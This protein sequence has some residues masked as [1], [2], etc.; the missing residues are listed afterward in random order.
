MKQLRPDLHIT[1]IGQTGDQLG[2]I[3]EQSEDIDRV[4]NVRAGK[5]RRYHGEGWRQLLDFSTLFKNLRDAF[6][7]LVGTWQSF[8]LLGKLR[9]AVIFTRGSYVSVPVCWAA[10]LRGIPYITHDSDAIPG[11]ANRII[12]PWAKIHAVALPKE[13]YSAYPADKIMTVGVPVSRN[14]G[15]VTSAQA[16][17]WREQLGL[18]QDSK[19]LLVTGGGNGADRLNKAVIACAPELLQRYP[20]LI[21]VHLTG[22]HLEA[23]ARRRYKQVLNPEEFERVVIKGFVTNLYQY[24]GAADVVVARA[25][26]TS[27]AEFAVQ[28]KACVIV[29]NPQLTGGHQPKNAKVL[30][31]RKAIR[32]V[33]EANLRNDPR[34]LM[35]A[36]TDLF[37]HPGKAK[38]LG[39]KLSALAQPNAAHL[40][41]EL[42]LELAEGKPVSVSKTHAN[43]NQAKSNHVLQKE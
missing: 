1:Y 24:S 8:W 23:D 37:D 5:F 43:K 28:A 18:E 17:A 39:A 3:P 26:G 20:D 36:L 4:V 40:L 14:F 27:M 31:D 7:L 34:A 9:P 30:A 12:A 11:L 22:R 10:A 41:A 15:K 38:L 32:M 35:P 2:D 42:L 25:G 33:S 29:P 6:W 13:V 19:V 21:I 16:A